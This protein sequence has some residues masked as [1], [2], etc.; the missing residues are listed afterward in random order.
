MVF[1]MNHSGVEID[2]AVHQTVQIVEHDPGSSQTCG[3]GG[4]ASDR[5]VEQSTLEGAD[6]GRN[7]YG[8]LASRYEVP[9]QYPLGAP[10]R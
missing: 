4:R 10:L 1:S 5:P 7:P 3:Y 6:R 9:R 2:R 8:R